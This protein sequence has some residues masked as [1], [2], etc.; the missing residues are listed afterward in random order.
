MQKDL[1]I[2]LVVPP[3]TY[4]TLDE[5][6]PACPH[7]GIA[8][9][10]S[11]LEKSQYK[12]DILDAFVL[13]ISK[14]KTLEEIKN[15]NP[16]IVGITAVTSEFPYAIDLCKE[17]KARFPQIITI[18]GGPHATI[19]PFTCDD[20]AIDYVALGEGEET[21]LELADFLLRKKGKK[22][23]INGIAYRENGKLK[24]TQSRA[25][26]NNLDDLPFPAYHLLPMDMYRPYAIFDLHRKFTSLITSRGCPYQCTYC[27][28]STVFGKRWVGMS[29]KRVFELLVYLQDSFGIN[30]FY[31]Q[32]DEF[33]LNHARI[34]ELCKLIIESKRDMIWECLARADHVTEE[35][36]QLMAQAGCRGIV[37]GA[38]M[39]YQW[40]LEKIKKNVK[41]EQITKAT[42]TCRRAGIN[43][44]VSF[45]MG[46]P[47]ESS[48]E[49]RQT[50]R[51]AKS[52]D[53][54]IA[55]FQILVPYPNTPL[56]KEIKEEGL[57]VSN[58]WNSYVQHSI[59]GTEPI[60]RT[61]YLSSRQLKFWNA[62]AFLAFYLRP[63]FLLRQILQRNKFGK[64][65]FYRMWRV[66]FGILRN[67]ILMM[68][69]ER[70]KIEK[71]KKPEYLPS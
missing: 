11:F 28:S 65:N 37:F 25:L 32:D 22:E 7:L 55:Y 3:F 5:A 21:M 6:G 18:L 26:I 27:T 35:M 50:I 15:C 53:V 36:I 17:I 38:E 61:R 69:P 19:M 39:G 40:G 30:H 70:K 33:T 4:A 45:M 63:R 52:L 66:G 46:F 10:A 8:C 23:N 64:R 67:A 51:F 29:A 16:K 20:L 43:T 68:L 47:W 56:Y 54:D 60:V 62:Y 41:L 2:L 57:I 14:E 31:F 59:V 42:S 49:I 71:T 9:L 34:E 12:V 13:R 48:K 1:D 58:D 24:L 44:R